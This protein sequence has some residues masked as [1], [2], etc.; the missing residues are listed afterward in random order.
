MLIGDKR[1]CKRSLCRV[2]LIICLLMSATLK[3]EPLR[4]DIRVL[5]KQQQPVA[6]AIVINP[7]IAL[8]TPPTAIAVMDQQNKQFT[9]RVLA[10]SRG[11]KVTFPNSDNIRHHVYSFSE[12]KRFEIKLY[13]D[14]PEAPIEFEKGGLVV[15]GC[16]IHDNML[17]YIF[18]SDWQHFA[19]TN[20]DGLA[21]LDAVAAA[22]KKLSLWHPD[23]V[24]PARLQDIE[25]LTWQ[26][27][28]PHTL[29]TTIIIERQPKAQP[30]KSSRFRYGS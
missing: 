9:P 23:Q 24:D 21:R 27:T 1:N 4:L 14:A 25:T 7:E 20:A 12:A 11:Q 10:I 17:G 5:D 2:G 22:P 26:S 28:G 30:I 16:N 6:D 3:A 13:A 29:S 15:L 18:V 8:T 19:L